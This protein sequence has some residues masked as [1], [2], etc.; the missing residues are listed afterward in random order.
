MKL[1]VFIILTITAI[2]AIAT[3]MLDHT[4][5]TAPARKTIPEFTFTDT[6]GTEHNIQDFRGKIVLLNF[7]ASWCA[8]CLKEFPAFIEIANTH[9]DIIIIALSSD[10]KDSTMN[11]FLT[12]MANTYPKTFPTKNFITALDTNMRITQ[13]LFKIMR[14]PE[15][16]I[17]DKQGQIRE[18]IIGANWTAADLNTKIKNLQLSP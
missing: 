12:K 15:T 4:T 3:Y 2:I 9:D 1:N 16:I 18:K 14:L 13:T 11:I 17:I 8:P 5:L 6:I 10:F 7:W